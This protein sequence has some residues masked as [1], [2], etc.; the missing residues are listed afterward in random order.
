[1]NNCKNACEDEAIYLKEF[2][3]NNNNSKLIRK[4]KKKLTQILLSM[5]K[6]GIDLK[7]TLSNAV[8]TGNIGKSNSND[9]IKYLLSDESTIREKMGAIS[10]VLE[11]AEKKK[12]KAHNAKLLYKYTM[13]NKNNSSVNKVY[14]L[15]QKVTKNKYPENLEYMTNDNIAL[16]WCPLIFAFPGYSYKRANINSK[17]VKKNIKTLPT[18]YLIEDLS[19]YEKKFLIKSNIDINK[20]ILDIETGMNLYGN[21]VCNLNYYTYNKMNCHVAGVSGHAILQ[22]T[23]GLIF[24]INWKYIFFAQLLEMIPVHHSIIEICWAANEM[25]YMELFDDYQEMRKEVNKLLND[26]SKK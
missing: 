12:P 11:D 24:N 5:E 7:E 15:I 22:Y 21:T 10:N 17:I 16:L 1:M 8:F 2:I 14:K 4:T 20:K 6:I 13:E 18:K 25:G 26:M 19:E 23:I 3:N 9:K